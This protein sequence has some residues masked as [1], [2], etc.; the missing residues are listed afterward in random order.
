MHT[1]ADARFTISSIVVGEMICEIAK[2]IAVGRG[3]EERVVTRAIDV[4]RIPRVVQFSGW[5]NEI[6]LI[7]NDFRCKDWWILVQV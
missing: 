3:A 7:E 6:F 4:E 1:C 5:I 2:T